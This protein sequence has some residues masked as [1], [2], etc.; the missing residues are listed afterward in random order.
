MS[1]LRFTPPTC[2]LEIK[3]NDSPLSRWTNRAVLKNLRF[4]LSFDD[5]KIPKEEQIA[6]QGDRFQLEQLYDAVIDYVGHFLHQSFTGEDIADTSSTASEQPYL[7]SQGMLAHVLWLGSLANSDASKIQLSSVQLFDLVT[8]LEEYHTQIVALPDLNASK[9]RRLLPIWGSI[10]AV[11]LVAIAFTTV[12]VQLSRQ[13]TSDSV[14]SSAKPESKTVPE[15]DDLA[16]PQVPQSNR[17]QLE[18]KPQQPLSS[19]EKLPPPPAV[20]VFKQQ[21]DIPDPAK[22]PL[23]EVAARA[24]VKTPQASPKVESTVKI[25]A[26]TQDGKAASNPVA[27]APP[28]TPA[29]QSPVTIPERVEPLE[30]NSD[31]VLNSRVDSDPL[32]EVSKYFAEKWQPPAE[33]K[34]SLEYRLLVDGSGKIQKVTPIGKASELYLYRTNI[35]L[36]GETFI[37][38]LKNKSQITVRLLLN[39]DGE[40]TTFLE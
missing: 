7:Q 2:T 13:K 39:P 18:P 15:L 37:S 29:S 12:G 21:P 3:A 24:G 8:A 23:P 20:D 25:P 11:T 36:K 27:I 10:A 5:P 40:I 14:V 22:Y 35:P 16:T 9:S 31:T 4:R 32:L 19:R 17:I 1:I 26:K 33:L 28:Q 30:S 6:I 38:P 34:Q